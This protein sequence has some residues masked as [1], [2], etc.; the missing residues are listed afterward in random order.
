MPSDKNSV[1]N[2]LHE[3]LLE[4]GI[5]KDRIDSAKFDFGFI[6]SFPPEPKSQNLSIYKLKNMNG[7][8]ITIRFQISKE[9]AEILNSFKDNRKL[10]FFNDL[11]KYLLIKEVFFKFVLQDL[12]VEIHE[13]IYPDEESF[14]SKNS[15]F[16][17]IQKVFY[18]YIFSNLLLEE[19]CMGKKR[20]ITNLGLF[21]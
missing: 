3:Y 13:Q 19:Y 4:E 20:P 18:C 1:E 17:L 7:I 8:F 15:L 14:I 11:R 12:I 6:I 21:Y 5:I 10:Q 9:K 16:K 2:L